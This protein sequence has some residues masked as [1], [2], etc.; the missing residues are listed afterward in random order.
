MSEN[1]II[2]GINIINGEYVEKAVFAMIIGVSL[3]SVQRY[4][5]DENNPLNDCL[6][7]DNECIH[8]QRGVCVYIEQVKNNQGGVKGRIERQKEQKLIKENRLL[9]FDIE[10][11]DKKTVSF[12]LV[13]QEANL[14]FEFWKQLAL[15][16]PGRH[17]D[18]ILNISDVAT[19]K[20]QLDIIIRSYLSE[21]H[22]NLQAFLDCFQ[23]DT[24]NR[25][26]IPTD[27][28]PM[29]GSKLSTTTERIGTGQVSK[30]KNA[31]SDT[32]SRRSKK[33]KV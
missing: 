16:Q 21:V 25:S 18:S 6:S 1:K 27:T 15:S 2:T 19:A 23:G 32:H 29:G 26:S 22:D 4:L 33:P 7:S 3:R 31:V 8:L 17:C 30:R 9:D 28:A 24:E 12:D 13:D 10:S 5:A 11:R 20:E 14:V